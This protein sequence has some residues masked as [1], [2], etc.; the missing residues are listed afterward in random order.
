VTDLLVTGTDTGVGKTLVAAGL[1]IALRARGV[2]AIGWKPVE[3]GLSPAQPADSTILAQATGLEERDPLAVPLLRLREPLAP[4]VAAQRAKTQLDPADVDLAL[5]RL[6][7]A[8]YRVVIEGAGGLLSPLAWSYTAL[9]LAVKGRLQA[10]VVARPGLGTLN[11]TLLTVQ[12]LQARRV[13]VRAV[14][15]SGA[16][17]SP[18]LAEQTNPDALGRLLPG[19][20]LVALPRFEEAD[21]LRRAQRAAPL[22]DPL[23]D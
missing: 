7:A 20:T 1:V 13:A 6:R 9:D 21:G 10:V 8:G 14:V 18:D 3:T 11:H 15:L 22:L 16:S 2:R 4:A 19:I 17:E 23:L 5:A 12:A